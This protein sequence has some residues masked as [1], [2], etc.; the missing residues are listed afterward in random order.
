MGSLRTEGALH[1]PGRKLIVRL[2]L[3]WFNPPVL[4]STDGL[5]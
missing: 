3:A 5:P 2:L 4:V 1:V